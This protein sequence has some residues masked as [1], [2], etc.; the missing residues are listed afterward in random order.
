MEYEAT[1]KRNRNNFETSTKNEEKIEAFNN[2]TNTGVAIF[3]CQNQKKHQILYESDWIETS[4]ELLN[5]DKNGVPYSIHYFWGN[6]DISEIPEGLLPN[7]NMVNIIDNPKHDTVGSYKL[8]ADAVILD[9]VNEFYFLRLS[10]END[11]EGRRNIFRMYWWVAVFSQTASV[12]LKIK[13]F[14]TII[15]PMEYYELREFK[16]EK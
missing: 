3:N 4:S 11:E 16:K 2:T 6:L 7:V 1:K 5:R 13:Y 14:V 10:E 15:N 9:S 8:E 12:Q